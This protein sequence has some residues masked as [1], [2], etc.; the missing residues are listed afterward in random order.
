MKEQEKQS[1]AATKACFEE[2]FKEAQFYNQQTQ[3]SEHLSK[4][5]SI[6][7]IKQGMRILDLGCGSGYLSFQAAGRNQE[8]QVVGLDIVSD[9]L[10]ANREHAKKENI[11]NVEFIS[12]DGIIFPFEDESFDMVITRYALHHFPTIQTSMNE[13]ARVLKKGGRFFLSDPR[14]NDCDTTR[15]VDAYMQLK[16]DGHI[17]F[18]TK[19]E[20]EEIMKEAGMMLEKSFDTSIRFPKKKN[21][22]PGYAEVLASHDQSII[23][24]YQLE[25]TDDELWIT[26]QVNNLMFV[27][28]I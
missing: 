25:E 11:T 6:L 2:S 10:V 20:W 5:L 19:A 17:R 3:D 24:S 22:A 1:I 16:K 9:A 18:Y 4:I 26:E 12:Y 13:V 28:Y 23:D 15:F 7:D 21:T 27:K 14:P 8:A